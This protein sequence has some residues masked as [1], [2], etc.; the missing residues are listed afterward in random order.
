MAGRFVGIPEVPNIGL[1]DWQGVLF[2]ALKENVELLT[3]T[4]GES[5]GFSKAVS[6][7]DVGVNK[8]GTQDMHTVKT[9]D[10]DGYTISSQDVAALTAF[11]NLRND[12]QSLANDLIKTRRAF[13]ALM[14]DLKGN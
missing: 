13:D 14:D 2:G 12:V 8:L 11:R 9:E 4:R 6:R 7:G 5:G 1:Q 3:G 10:V